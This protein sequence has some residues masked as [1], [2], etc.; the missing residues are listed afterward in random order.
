MV[1]GRNE[2]LYMFSSRSILITLLH[3]YSVLYML[4]TTKTGAPV[5]NYKLRTILGV[6]LKENCNRHVIVC[7]DAMANTQNVPLTLIYIIFIN[8]ENISVH[9]DTHVLR[10]YTQVNTE[11][12]PN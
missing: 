6:T 11:M 5:A 4:Y 10:I 9:F 3:M 12:L 2:H 7:S 1:D 8:D